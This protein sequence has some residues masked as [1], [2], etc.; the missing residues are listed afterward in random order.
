MKREQ[1]EAHAAIVTAVDSAN[2]DSTQAVIRDFLTELARCPDC[3]GSGEVTVHR[4]IRVH[5]VVDSYHNQGPLP[6]S[7]PEGESIPMPD[8]RHV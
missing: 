1:A 8:V 3:D 5:A 7:I 6:A 4:E 2:L